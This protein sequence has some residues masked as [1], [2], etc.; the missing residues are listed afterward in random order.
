MVLIAAPDTLKQFYEVM[1][2]GEPLVIIFDKQRDDPYSLELHLGPVRRGQGG[3]GAA[4]V[5]RQQLHQ[6]SLLRG[7]QGLAERRAGL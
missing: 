2:G 6:P 3:R 5:S 4:T 1:L 7:L